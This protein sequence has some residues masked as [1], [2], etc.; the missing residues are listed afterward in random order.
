MGKSG[1][2]SFSQEDAL[3]HLGSRNIEL[4][5]LNGKYYVGNGQHRVAAAHN[6]GIKHIKAIVRRC[7]FEGQK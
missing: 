7:D 4:F 2:K 1:R 5:E 3:S 6:L